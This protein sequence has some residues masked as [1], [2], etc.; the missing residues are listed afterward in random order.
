MCFLNVNKCN[1]V[2]LITN[3]KQ[4]LNNT[5]FHNFCFREHKEIAHDE[6]TDGISIITDSDPESS[7]CDLSCDKCT[8]EES[9]P[10]EHQDT[11]YIFSEPISP[12]IDNESLENHDDF[13]GENNSKHKTYVH[14]RNK[15]LSTML[16]IIMLG[17]IITA[18]GV[19]IGHMWGARNECTM[20][21]TP[22]VNKILSNLYKLQE[23][24][25]FLRNKLKE[26]TLAGNIQLQQQKKVG[27]DK[28][29]P[30]Q[31]RCKKMFEEPLHNKMKK[32]FKCV[33]KPEIKNE[34]L[35]D[36]EMEFL[37]DI[38]K[39]KTV[40]HQ[41]KSWLDAAI[42]KKMK[43]EEKAVRNLYNNFKNENTAQEP[44]YKD[45]GS[46]KDKNLNLIKVPKV[47]DENFTVLKENEMNMAKEK[48]NSAGN[49]KKVSYADSL[50]SD[51]PIRKIRQLEVVDMP[52]RGFKDHH[53]HK[54]KMKNDDIIPSLNSLSEEDFKKDD[55]YTGPKIKQ[56]RKKHDRQKLHKKQ[57]RKNKYEQWEM[58]GGYLKDYDEFSL[59]SS[60]GVDALKNPEKKYLNPDFE[61]YMNKFTETE[62]DQLNKY[63]KYDDKT[64]PEKGAFKNDKMKK[65]KNKDIEWYDKRSALR[66]EA[67]K[68]LEHELFGD[69]SPNAASWYFRRMQKR[70]QCRAQKDNSTFKK[71]SKQKLNFKMKR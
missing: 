10:T 28:V 59:T 51:Q 25:A 3:I 30:K 19:A 63:N 46:H 62:N 43:F 6:D 53:I 36:H 7:P 41:N 48:A 42:S 34:D 58:K 9:R 56:E 47:Y 26:L 22:S 49:E 17:S 32:G 5:Y 38:T 50:K 2:T 39:L 37:D 55:R 21:T 23:E 24:N 61:N 65:M 44:Q 66:A 27:S 8:S 57:K 11:S 40:Y 13:L 70:E 35:P 31:Q 67:R 71:F 29:V 16:N 1:C 64:K 68:K 12:N 14:R 45:M 69:T 15:R 33:D 60:M 20:H 18:A 54:K 52:H 4:R